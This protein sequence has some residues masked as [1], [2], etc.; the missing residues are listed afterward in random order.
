YGT[1]DIGLINGMKTRMP[2]T[3]GTLLL[4]SL[5]VTGAPPFASF[6]GE[7][8]IIYQLISLGYLLEVF[9]LV[10]TLLIIS[11]SVMYK[12]SAMIFEGKDD[13]PKAEP[14]IS[15]LLVT[16]SSVILCLSITFLYLGGLIK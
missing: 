13:M 9:L 3:S 1:R 12:V 15:Q 11:V 16:V 14:D 7:F 6:I 2:Y 4:S 8:L 10:F 5:A